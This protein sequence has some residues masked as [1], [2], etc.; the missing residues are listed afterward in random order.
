MQLR[1][2]S[3]RNITLHLGRPMTS[4][5][6]DLV[7]LGTVSPA[8]ADAIEV[9]ERLRTLLDLAIAIGEREGLLGRNDVT[10]GTAVRNDKKTKIGGSSDVNKRSI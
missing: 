6:T 7:K 9:K 10:K 4:C 5:E 3:D 8:E 2:P 1:K